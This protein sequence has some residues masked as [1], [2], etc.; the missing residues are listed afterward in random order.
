MKKYWSNY[1]QLLPA[2]N[3]W[4]VHPDY[5]FMFSK[6]SRIACFLLFCFLSAHQNTPWNLAFRLSVPCG[7]SVYRPAKQRAIYHTNR[8]VTRKGSLVS[9]SNGCCNTTIKT[10]PTLCFSC[11]PTFVERYRGRLE[12]ALQ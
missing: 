2:F 1:C 9:R 5:C 6:N 8:L 12:V 11:C 7:G 4:S 3:V 10:L